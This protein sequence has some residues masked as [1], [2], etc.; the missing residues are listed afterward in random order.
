MF[1]VEKEQNMSQIYKNLSNISNIKSE[2]LCKSNQFSFIASQS[3]SIHQLSDAEEGS[4]LAPDMKV[5]NE[6][7]N[8]N[9]IAEESK[10]QSLVSN[11]SLN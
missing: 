6:V 11:N 2:V 3:E 10:D 1:R 7:G 8:L 4:S 5:Q 9:I